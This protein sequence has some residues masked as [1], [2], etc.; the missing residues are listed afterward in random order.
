M[1]R[2]FKTR[3][4]ENFREMVKC[5]QL[6]YGDEKPKCDEI[7]FWLDIIE[8]VQSGKTII[9]GGRN[10]RMINADKYWEYLESKEFDEPIS[11]AILLEENKELKDNNARFIKKCER[12]LELLKTDGCNSKLMVANDIQA[13]LEEIEK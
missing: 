1:S 12:W 2:K 8:K 5:N 13:M 6:D 3:M 11:K 7:E 10:L 9:F 4:L